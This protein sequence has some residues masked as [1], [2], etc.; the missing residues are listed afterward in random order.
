MGFAMEDDILALD[1]E[2]V[3]LPR[4]FRRHVIG[5]TLST[6]C[7]EFSVRPRVEISHNQADL[8]L[9]M[10]WAFG[11]LLDAPS[12]ASVSSRFLAIN[13]PSHEKAGNTWFA[14]GAG[15]PC[16]C[17]ERNRQASNLIAGEHMI[18]AVG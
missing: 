3:D 14:Q 16:A 4:A 11:E 5:F 10:R 13:Q 12:I 7:T 1:D 6:L 2:V 17:A 15:I 8:H 18:V 9:V